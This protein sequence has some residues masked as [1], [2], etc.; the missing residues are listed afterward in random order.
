MARIATARRVPARGQ[1][2]RPRAFVMLM[3]PI[4]V[5]AELYRKGWSL[6][7]LA[8]A[9]GV[10]PSVVSRALNDRGSSLRVQRR[11]ERILGREVWKRRLEG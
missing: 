4:D 8:Q 7:R 10:S 3:H 9:L 1:R 5:R 2:G 6:R 11:V